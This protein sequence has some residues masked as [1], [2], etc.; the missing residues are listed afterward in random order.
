VKQAEALADQCEK[1][2]PNDANGLQ[3]DIKAYWKNN[4]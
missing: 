4:S 1:Y 2:E 3:K